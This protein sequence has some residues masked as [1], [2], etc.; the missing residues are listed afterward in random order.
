VR[1]HINYTILRGADTQTAR[2]PVRE[3]FLVDQFPRLV[4]IDGNGDILWRSRDRLDDAQLAEL[5]REIY[6]KL[7][8]PTK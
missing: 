2:C 8:P 1:Y 6:R 4:L 5:E 3:Q 7:H